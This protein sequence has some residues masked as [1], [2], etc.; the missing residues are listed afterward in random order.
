MKI[1]TLNDILKMGHIGDEKYVRYEEIEQLKIEKEWLFNEY[2]SLCFSSGRDKHT[3][4]AER[5]ILKEI[6]QAM[7]KYL[8]ERKMEKGTENVLLSLLDEG[9]IIIHPAVSDLKEI[10]N[11]RKEVEQ[12]TK[13]SEWL[14]GQVIK[15]KWKS[16]WFSEKDYRKSIIRQMQKELKE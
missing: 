1:Y 13:R 16:N 15:Y 10:Q 9:K 12:L 2:V 11:L 8:K 7:Q 14:I 5:R 6:Q 4:H 3:G